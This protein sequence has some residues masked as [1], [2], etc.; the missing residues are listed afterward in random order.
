M[1]YALQSTQ[2][3]ESGQGF[4]VVPQ[5]GVQE[6]RFGIF[7]VATDGCTDIATLDL[8]LEL[9]YDS[10]EEMCWDLDR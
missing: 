1:T 4:A 3:K 8:E 6:K 2:L 9:S 10:D 5:Q 7:L